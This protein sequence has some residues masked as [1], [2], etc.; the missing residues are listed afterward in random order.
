M[1]IG[2]FARGTRDERL[3]YWPLSADAGAAANPR[4]WGN[5]GAGL[6]LD[7]DEVRPACRQ[8]AERKTTS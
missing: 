7:L 4:G 2:T 6:K 3:S 5:T 1:L 8:T